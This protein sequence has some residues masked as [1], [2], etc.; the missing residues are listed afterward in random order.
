MN[1][2]LKEQ[3]A[4]IKNNIS[5]MVNDSEIENL[6]DLDNTNDF[7]IQRKLDINAN[8]NLVGKTYIIQLEKYLLNPPPNFNLHVNWNHGQIPANEYMLCEV[9]QD[10]GKMIKILAVGYDIINDNSLPD[11]WEGWLP[12]KSIKIIKEL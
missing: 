9:K 8:T 6:D 5:I 12:K 2:F 10:L 7:I 4:K 1:Q 3:L 11:L